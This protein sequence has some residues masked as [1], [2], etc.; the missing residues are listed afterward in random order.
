M[1]LRHRS[2][3]DKRQVQLTFNMEHAD[4]YEKQHE[5]IL[6]LIDHIISKLEPQ[7]T[8]QTISLF[9]KIADIA[10]GILY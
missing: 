2:A 3:A 6:S 1:I 9:N 10:D 7:E 4:Q 8:A 5:D